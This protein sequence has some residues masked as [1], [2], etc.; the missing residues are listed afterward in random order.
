MLIDFR[1]AKKL[2]AQHDSPLMVISKSRIR[3][4]Y[5]TLKKAMPRAEIHYAMK[6]NP[7]KGIL[8]ILR[9]EGSDFDVASYN[10]IK[11]LLDIEVDSTNMIYA[12]PVKAIPDLVR[13]YNVGVEKFVFDNDVELQK[14]AR[15]APE[16]DV[17]LRLYA[18]GDNAY[19]KL[20]TKFGA[21]PKDAIRLLKKAK[22]L[23]LDPVGICFNVGCQVTRS[24]GYIQAVQAA[25]KIFKEAKKNGIELTTLDIGGGFPVRYGNKK[26]DMGGDFDAKTIISEVNAAIEEH[27]PEH[28]KIIA[29]P[30]RF[31][32]GD[33]AVLIMR[34]IGLSKRKGVIWYYVD[35]GYYHSYSDIHASDWKFDF[36]PQSKG[37]K[38]RSVLAGPTC[39]SFDVIAKNIWLPE[40]EL[41]ELIMSPN[42]GAYTSG[43]ASNFNGFPPAKTVFVD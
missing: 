33:A 37:R 34:V 36:V 10:E 32:I 28:I 19:Y 13:A 22:R 24:D 14:M 29:E 8:N 11:M 42:M 40:L 15:Y 30:G 31:I 6:A 23:G 21:Q 20:S 3:Q 18:N 16:S 27:V 26:T 7:H 25:M 39:D 43:M 17:L 12:N 35:D 4:N 9:E 41:G 1:L 38:I 5:Q 2:V